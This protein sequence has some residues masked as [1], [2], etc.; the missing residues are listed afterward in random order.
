M[1]AEVCFFLHFAEALIVRIGNGAIITARET[2]SISFFIRK[3]KSK[4]TNKLCV[5]FSLLLR[6]I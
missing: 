5:F 1:Q 6:Y 4:K 3:R 2:T